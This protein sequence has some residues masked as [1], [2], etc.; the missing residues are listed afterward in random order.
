M[1]Y[2]IDQKYNAL[3]RKDQWDEITQK[4]IEDRIDIETGIKKKTSFFA[5]DEHIVLK[6]LTDL[7]VPQKDADKYIDI[8]SSI[9]RQITMN[10]NGVRYGNDPWN[11][12]FYKKGL[13]LLK[14]NS[15]QL[16]KAEVSAIMDNV[17]GDFL[18]RFVRK[19]LADAIRIY[20]SHPASWNEIGFPGPAFPEGYSSLDCS[21]A[22][23]WEP[24]YSKQ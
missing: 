24:K 14:E 9:G 6:N 22:E 10:K 20:Y 19:V 1:N 3:D 8:A 16:N 13:T 4:V 18:M 2:S 7:L 12:E 11:G 17:R 21:E 5:E 23:E 15:N